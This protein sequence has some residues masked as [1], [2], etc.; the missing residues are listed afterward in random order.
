MKDIL[1]L[2]CSVKL[3]EQDDMGIVPS[4]GTSVEITNNVLYFKC[5]HCGVH[6]EVTKEASKFHLYV[7]GFKRV[8]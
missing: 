1:C 3:G 6:R 2:E 4:I 5:P 8:Y 7:P